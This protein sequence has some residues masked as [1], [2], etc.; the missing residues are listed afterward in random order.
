MEIIHIV[1]G[2]ANPERMNGVNKVVYELA[3]QQHLN[4]RRVQL[5]GITADTGAGYGERN[6]ETRLFQK[7]SFPFSVHPHLLAAISEKKGQA[8][9]HL[10]GGWIPVFSTIASHLRKEK[11]PYVLTPHGAYN[12]IA[13]KKSAWRKKI[14]FQLFEK[15]LAAAAHT[16]HCIGQSETEGLRTLLPTARFALVPY[17]YKAGA[18]RAGAVSAAGGFIIGFIGRL[19]IHTKGL[20]LL[21]QAFGQ[22]AGVHPQARLWIIGDSPQR[23]VLNRM[24]EARHITDKVVVWGAKFGREKEELM[25]AMHLFVHPS[26]NEGLPASVLEAA[27]CGIPC[28]VSKATNLAACI[29]EY[30]AG[31]GI[32]DEDVSALTQALNEAI[33]E[34]KSGQLAL[35]ATRA[36]QMVKE[37]FSWPEVVARFDKLYAL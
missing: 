13:M 9:F 3:T 24:I 15:K 32:P 2:K 7:Q 12:T 33:A 11:I 37:V 22:L 26:R 10:H 8:V 14:Y 1:L 23:D 27:A 20:D 19:D 31:Y 34:E 25:E 29:S 4:G 6:F 5:W 21:I 28:L 18:P 30:G 35:R 16:I 17:G 36:V